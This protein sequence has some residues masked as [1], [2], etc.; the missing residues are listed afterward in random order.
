MMNLIPTLHEDDFV[1]RRI[2]G[3]FATDSDKIKAVKDQLTRTSD[4][5]QAKLQCWTSEKKEQ[6]KCGAVVCNKKDATCIAKTVGEINKLEKLDEQSI[7]FCLDKEVDG[8]EFKDVEWDAKSI[9]KQ[10][11]FAPAEAYSVESIGG[12]A[13][14]NKPDN[15]KE[16][17]DSH[18]ANPDS[19][20]AKP[21]MEEQ[22][23]N[24][25]T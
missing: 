21:H 14:F 4:I 13:A 18:E 6:D 10:N 20:E 9:C 15:Q 11:P 19:Q 17:P 7:Y 16:K 25:S 1:F 8:K 12:F 22:I 2:G 24:S 23:H 3:D 5:A